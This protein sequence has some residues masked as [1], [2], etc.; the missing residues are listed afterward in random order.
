MMAIAGGISMFT[1]F[2]YYMVTIIFRL[3]GKS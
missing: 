2:V 1:A 3:H